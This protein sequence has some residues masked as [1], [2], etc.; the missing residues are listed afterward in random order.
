MLS[1]TLKIELTLEAPIISRSAAVGAFG[2]DAV[3]ARSWD[4]RICLPRKLIKGCLRQ[5]W[6]ELSSATDGA[7]DID[8]AALLGDKSENRPD[9]AN[10]V[11]P[12]RSRLLFDDFVA[13][14]V[15]ISEVTYRI[16]IDSE[17]GAVD[18]G[19][20]QVIESPFPAGA[21]V[22]FK[23]QVRFFA[24]DKVE[25]DNITNYVLGGL[26]WVAGYGALENVG[27]GRLVSASL[28]KDSIQA[29]VE[30]VPGP[31]LDVDSIDLTITPCA[32]FCIAKHRTDG[33]FFE[34]EAFIPGGIIKGAIADAWLAALGSQET[35]VST[36]IKNSNMPELC[37]SFDRIRFTHAFPSRGGKHRPVQWPISIVRDSDGN[38]HDVALDESPK[39]FP[40]QGKDK[41][42][43]FAP[44]F[45]LDWKDEGASAY[46][47][48]GWA[49]PPRRLEMHT[50][51]ENNK[52]K[53]GVLFAYE[54]VL[55]KDLESGASFEWYSSV[56]LAGVESLHRPKVAAQLKAVLTALGLNGF[57]KTKARAAV[58][59]DIAG[60]I[61]P[62]KQS[63]RKAQSGNTWIVTL[64]T[65]ALLCDPWNLHEGDRQIR[66]KEEYG[67]VWGEL[68]TRGDGTPLVDLV[69]FFARQTLAGGA[70]L[71]GRFS[72]SKPYNPYILTDAGSVFVLKAH[73][74]GEAEVEGIVNTWLNHGLPL[75]ACAAARYG[76]NWRTCPYIRENGYGEIALNIKNTAKFR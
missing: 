66:L 51:I 73:P 4:G 76:D 30:I 32:P 19:A 62:K 26:R 15:G 72:K 16:S 61:K 11:E 70:Y 71:Q 67:R 33:N 1:V 44:S 25:A 13:D 14:H 43:L 55:P 38:H 41:N 3:M 2:V 74:G 27:F 31:E 12:Y 48:Y 39:C 21:G 64:Q 59:V 36:N 60:T 57:G 50:E 7:F 8:L 18:E 17:R 69:R 54:T 6:K 24:Q 47:E 75:P 40:A 68:G 56:D 49:D 23:G 63:I 9:S 10:G 58:I 5:A 53:T 37:A 22:Q 35:V 45:F 28:E 42:E 65:P 29:S 34:S 20:Y 52:P 46:Q